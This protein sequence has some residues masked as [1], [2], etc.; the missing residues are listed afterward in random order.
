M[1]YGC[2]Q[3]GHLRGYL[4]ASQRLHPGR[5]G[6]KQVKG[7]PY[8]RSYYKCSHPGCQVK[9]IV[10]RNP[11]NGLVSNASSK[12]SCQHSRQSPLFLARHRYSPQKYF[13]LQN[14]RKFA[15]SQGIHSHAKPGSMPGS[16]YSGRGRFSARGGRSLQ[17]TLC[18][19]VFRNFLQQLV[20]ACDVCELSEID[21]ERLQMGAGAS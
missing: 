15:H 21:A 2:G 17:V 7:S 14:V 3:Y 6:E 18:D 19:P 1:K 13:P 5:Y 12:V 11:E 20:R 8:P 9:K 4:H 10:E 16:G